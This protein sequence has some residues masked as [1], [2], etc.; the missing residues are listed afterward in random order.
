ME[1]LSV[2]FFRREGFYRQDDKTKYSTF[3]RNF[4]FGF[5]IVTVFFLL[6]HPNRII[7]D[8]TTIE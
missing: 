7:W 6:L 2:S 3:N 1:N 8:I 4:R 5:L